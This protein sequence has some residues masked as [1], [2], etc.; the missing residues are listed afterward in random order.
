MTNK[1]FVTA[2]GEELTLEDAVVRAMRGVTAC[3]AII[4]EQ[5]ILIE[6]LADRVNM[7]EATL[8]KNI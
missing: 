7:L 6:K 1:L 2:Q 3:E 8:L 5:D 4:K